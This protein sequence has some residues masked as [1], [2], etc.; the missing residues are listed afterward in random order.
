MR[1]KA[2]RASS[3]GPL[4]RNRRYNENVISYWEK[5]ATANKLVITRND[6]ERLILCSYS[7]WA[8]EEP[9]NDD[10]NPNPYPNNFLSIS[11]A[12]SASAKNKRILIDDFNV[13]DDN[14]KD[15]ADA[16]KNGTA[17]GI[18]DGSFRP[19]EEAGTSSF[20]ISPGKTS[21]HVMK[22]S[23]WVPGVKKE[24]SAY[25]SELAGID[26]ILSVLKVIVDFYKIRSGSIELALDGESAMDQANDAGYLYTSQK[27]FD[28]IH[29][30][31]ARVKKLP[32]KIQWRHVR[33]HASEKGL[34]QDWWTSQNEKVDAAAKAFM[35]KCLEKNQ[36]HYTVLLWNEV[37]ALYVNGS[38]QSRICKKSIYE[39]LYGERRIRYWHG[40][41]DNSH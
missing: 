27:S 39:S 40:H 25:R 33:G 34:A 15:I 8:Y 32:I 22:G 10:I 20:R 37:V 12:F 36:E 41:H 35:R 9:E 16:I 28:I 26:G 17:R 19:E 29:D 5:P 31:R 23:N 18:S 1:W 6:G 7:S 11:E 21:K 13:P 3:N 24:Q 30:I 14:C 38:K 4:L 2:Y